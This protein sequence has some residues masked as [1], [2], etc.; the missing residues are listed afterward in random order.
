[1]EQMMADESDREFEV[2]E[3]DDV[4]EVPIINVF[5][6]I[7]LFDNIF[8]HMQAMNIAITDEFIEHQEEELLELYIETERTPIEEVL[9]VSALS[10]LWIF[11]L[12]ELL[13]T[14]RQQVKELIDYAS[15]VTKDKK[16]AK[17][18][19]DK[20]ADNLKSIR[21][22]I[23]MNFSYYERAMEKARRDGQ[24]VDRLKESSLAI[25]PLF[26]IIEAL[27]ITLAKHEVPKTQG[28]YASAPGYGRIDM[29]TG[30]IY[31]MVDYKEGYSEIVSRRTIAREL[32]KVIRRLGEGEVVRVGG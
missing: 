15:E 29:L 24:F 31:W 21:P 28:M 3:E 17:H 7:P 5:R 14:W 18:T 2:D 19:K 32:R 9:F 27:R 26:R 30:S 1:V 16:Q 23:N 13:R 10:Q 12:Y 20:K 8:L 4:D 22:E 6:K 25:E 11:G